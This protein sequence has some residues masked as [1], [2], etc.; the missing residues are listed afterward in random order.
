MSD[1]GGEGVEVG[2]GVYLRGN[3]RDERTVLCVLSPDRALADV[4]GLPT[5]I[6]L[7]EGEWRASGAP[8]TDA[9]YERAAS[10]VVMPTETRCTEG[11]Q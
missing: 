7:V 9:E 8:L 6:D 3:E 4:D 5:P 2:D 1:P 11:E 10:V